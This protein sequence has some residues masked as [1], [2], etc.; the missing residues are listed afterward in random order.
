MRDRII[1]NVLIKMGNR[2]KKKKLQF[3]ENV[4]VE[5]LGNNANQEST[6]LIKYN[7]STKNLRTCCLATLMVRNKSN[8]TIKQ[9]NLHLT[10]CRLLC[11]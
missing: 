9:Y 8:R 5:E 10:I 7:D 11:R 4:L 6:D 1:S 2:I 3:L